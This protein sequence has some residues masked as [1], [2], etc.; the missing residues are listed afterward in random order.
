MILCGRGISSAGEASQRFGGHIGVIL[1]LA[2]HRSYRETTSVAGTRRNL[3]NLR[4]RVQLGSTYL[5]KPSR[6]F[7]SCDV[8]GFS[9]ALVTSCTGT[10]SRSR[11]TACSSN[12]HL[13]RRCAVLA[14]CAVWCSSLSHTL[15]S[16]FFLDG[17]LAPTMDFFPHE[18]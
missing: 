11:K 13:R 7:G 10:L 3:A 8:F 17:S 18:R 9:R 4:E 5:G 14:R 6:Q 2:A 15:S 1:K 16:A 12:C